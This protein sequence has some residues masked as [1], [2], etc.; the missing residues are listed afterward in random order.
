[1]GQRVKKR[2]TSL[3]GDEH[4]VRIGIYFVGDP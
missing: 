3:S 4:H 1:M 2:L